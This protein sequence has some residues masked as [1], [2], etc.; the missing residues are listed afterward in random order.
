MFTVTKWYVVPMFWGPITAYLLL[1]S[2]FQFTGPLPKF[3]TNPALPLSYISTVPVE[4]YFKVMACFLLGTLIWTIL[5]YTMHRFLFH[6]DGLLPDTPAFITLHFLM[7]GIHHYLPMDQWVDDV[8]QIFVFFFFNQTLFLGFALSCRRCYSLPCSYPLP[9][10]R[11]SYSRLLWPMVSL[12]VLSRFVSRLYTL[13]PR[14]FPDLKGSFLDIL[15]DC[16][17]YG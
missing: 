14:I 8:L 4:S 17:H 7:H 13:L 16:M 3:F 12:V 15:Y 6:I 11:M 1:R 2:L 9:N 10:W 5:E